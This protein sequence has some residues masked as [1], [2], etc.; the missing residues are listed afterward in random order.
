MLYLSH[1]GADVYALIREAAGPAF[2]VVT[3]ER[4]DDDERCRKIADCEGVICAAL[5]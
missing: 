4:D 1:A 2:E 3:L 5:D